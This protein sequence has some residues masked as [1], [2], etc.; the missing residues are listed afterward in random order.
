MVGPLS[1]YRISGSG[2]FIDGTEEQFKG[3]D[4]GGRKE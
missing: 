1:E 3:G 2:F 4:G